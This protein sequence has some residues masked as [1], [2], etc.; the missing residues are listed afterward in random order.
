ML[1]R[2]IAG[3]IVAAAALVVADPA[4]AGR[5][6]SDEERQQLDDAL[7]S[8]GFTRWG[9]VELDDGVWKVSD[10]EGG[11]GNPVDLKLREKSYKVIDSNIR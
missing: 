11:T 8:L 2:T 9:D 4:R 6:P 5:A 3:M 7:H 10:A 1:R